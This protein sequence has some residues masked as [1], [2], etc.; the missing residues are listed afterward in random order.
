M[1]SQWVNILLQGLDRCVPTVEEYQIDT[2]ILESFI[3]AIP[4]VMNLLGWQKA[5]W[6]SRQFDHA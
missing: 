6:K 5:L 3:S 4:P 1:Y 2:A